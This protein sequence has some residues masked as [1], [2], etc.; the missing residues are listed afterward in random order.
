MKYKFNKRIDNISED[1]QEKISNIDLLKSKW[2]SGS[3]LDRQV[4]E[5]L[6]KSVL[7]TSTGASTRIEGSSLSDED[8]ERLMRGLSLQTFKDRD[9]Q[10]VR[11][12]F[13]LLDNI[14]SSYTT[15]PFSESTIKFFHKE[16]LKYTDKDEQHRGEYKKTENKVAMVSPTGE[17]VEILFDTTD[18]WKTPKEMQELV[19]WTQQSFLEKEIHPLYII[20]NFIVEFLHIHPFEDGNG[21]LSRI[22]TNLLLL[23]HGYKYIPYVSHEK[24]VEENKINYYLALRN[25]Q[26]TFRSGK[27]DLS[28]W[29][30]FFC[31]VLQTQAEQSLYL[32]SK[33][34]VT[35]LLSPQQQK[36]WGYVLTQDNEFTPR[37]L[38]EVTKIPRPTI[39]Q[40]LEKLLKNKWVEKRGLGRGTRYVR[41]K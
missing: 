15:I 12:Y 25:S 10:E 5:G 6:K 24:V 41:I 36:V 18:A 9:K 26:K 4:L 3:E 7:I 35:K 33:T 30:N 40:V 39:N 21:R 37:E 2:I 31:D 38:E 27:E 34:E 11:G 16:I 13:E 14:F 17:P 23:Q 20:G 29:M 22:L 19:E 8:V 32:I 1:I 28:F